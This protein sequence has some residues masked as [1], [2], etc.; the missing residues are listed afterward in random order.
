MK[1]GDLVRVD[2]SNKFLGIITGVDASRGVCK[3]LCSVGGAISTPGATQW[4][5]PR[6]LEVVS[7]GR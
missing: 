2:L 3:V 4:I 6:L 1:V 7:E 5:A